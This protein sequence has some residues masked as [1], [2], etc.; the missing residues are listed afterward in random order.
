VYGTVPHAGNGNVIFKITRMNVTAIFID[1]P[2]SLYGNDINITAICPLK[3]TCAIQSPLGTTLAQ[4]IGMATYEIKGKSSRDAVG[5][6]AY[7]ANDITKNKYVNKTLSINPLPGKYVIPIPANYNV[8]FI[9]RGA[10]GGNASVGYGGYGAFVSGTFNVLTASNLTIHI[11]S[12][13]AEGVGYIGAYGGNFSSIILNH[14]LI[15]IAGGGG[16][17]GGYGGNGGGGVNG[18]NAGENGQTGDSSGDACS[19]GGGGA[20]Q[21]GPGGGGIVWRTGCGYGN[22]GSGEIGGAPAGGNY[23]NGGGGGGG[24][25]YFGGGSGGSGGFYSPGA[26]GGGGSSFINP[27]VQN[28]AYGSLT[29]PGNGVVIIKITQIGDSSNVYCFSRE[30]C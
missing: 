14:T 30:W 26:G 4:G 1:P 29:Y 24:N 25:G 3:D 5:I 6:Y 11:G 13:G 19:T 16:G 23:G 15:A 20:T 10:S 17:S 9:V 2:S 27:L 21:S 18:G 28:Q 8:S 12:I 7:Y 22:G